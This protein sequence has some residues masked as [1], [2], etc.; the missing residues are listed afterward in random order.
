MNQQLI[1][2]LILLYLSLDNVQCIFDSIFN[3]IFSLVDIAND[4]FSVV[5]DIGSIMSGVGNVSK[6]KDMGSLNITSAL[7]FIFSL[8]GIGCNKKTRDPFGLTFESCPIATL[9]TCPD[10]KCIRCS[11]YWYKR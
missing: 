8:L 10:G 6:I 7:D 9:L 3:S 11:T 4:I 2:L 1:R 5:N